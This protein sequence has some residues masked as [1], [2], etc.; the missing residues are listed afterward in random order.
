MNREDGSQSDWNEPGS[1][2]TVMEPGSFHVVHSRPFE[3]KSARLLV[4]SAYH[5]EQL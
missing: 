4:L 1:N 5:D 3:R 2:V